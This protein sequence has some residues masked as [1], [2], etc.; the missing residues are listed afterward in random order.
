MSLRISSDDKLLLM[1]AAA[2]QHINLTGFVVSTK[3]H[4]KCHDN[5]FWS[6]G[7]SKSLACVIICDYLS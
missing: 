5:H 2:L 4:K 3:V 7:G 1:R 6:N